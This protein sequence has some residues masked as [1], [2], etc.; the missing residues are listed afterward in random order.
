MVRVYQEPVLTLGIS[1]L[2][3]HFL[4]TKRKKSKHIQLIMTTR[5]S[6]ELQ[7]PGN[8]VG[9]NIFQNMHSFNRVDANIKTRLPNMSPA[10]LL[11]SLRRYVLGL[12]T[13][14]GEDWKLNFI[15]SPKQAKN[16]KKKQRASTAAGNKLVLK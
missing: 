10:L 14:S 6:F 16:I 1:R 2:I 9:G 3:G 15:F 8:G 13:K 12:C 7:T 4:R 5:S 11:S